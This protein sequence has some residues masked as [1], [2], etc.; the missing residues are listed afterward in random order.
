MNLNRVFI[1]INDKRVSVAA[2]QAMDK[3][4]IEKVDASGCTALTALDAP[5]ARTVYANGCTALTALDAPK[6]GTVYANGCTAL[7][8][9][10]APEAGY[11]YASGCT[12]LA[13]VFIAGVDSRGYT[14]FGMSQ[15][16]ERRVFAGCRNFTVE[17]AL[18][19]W[20]P[21]GESDHPDCVALVQLII[22]DNER[23]AAVA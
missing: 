21:G 4:L 2:F 17:T 10:D 3:S 18:R 13:D 9:L 16:G 14:F 15:R 11:V 6:A 7:T 8:A 19:H 5:K 22:A 12:A 23:R 1:L 20:G